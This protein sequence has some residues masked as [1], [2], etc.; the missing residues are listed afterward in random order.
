MLVPVIAPG[1]AEQTKETAVYLMQIMSPLVLFSGLLA[2]STAMINT[3]R[4]F[5]YPAFAALLYNICIIGS[6]LF[7][8][9]YLSIT[10]LALGVVVGTIIQLLAQSTVLTKKLKLYTFSFDLN[11]PGVK[12][13][14]LLIVPI[15]IGSAAGQL[16]LIVDRILASGLIEGSIAALHF[17]TRVMQLPLGIFA[18][19][20]GVALYPTLSQQVAKGELNNLRATLS[21]GLRITWFIII[22]VS[23]GMIVLHEPIIRLLFERGALTQLL[24]S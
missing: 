24:P 22:P 9:N 2:L 17:A 23:V 15:I 13:A 5:I 7:L 6:I 21:L 19:A 20:V 14:A 11:H 16:N 1:L 18:A 8:T 10:A 12:K 3:Y 4:H